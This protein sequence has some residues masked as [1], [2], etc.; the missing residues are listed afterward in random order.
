MNKEMAS[1]FRSV[2]RRSNGKVSVMKPPKPKNL[3]K[4][5]RQIKAGCRVG[6]MR[7]GK[8]IF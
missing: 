6:K 1:V 2:V 5:D 4:L 3:S 8:E 7:S